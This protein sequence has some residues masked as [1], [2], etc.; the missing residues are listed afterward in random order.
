MQLRAIEPHDI[1]LLYTIEND[2]DL[3]DVSSV[4]V[5]YSRYDLEQY[6]L[7]QRHD[8]Y[9]DRQLRLV[10]TADDGKAVGLIDL[11]DFSPANSRAE[12]G[13]AIL[14]EERGKG[15]AV[16]A[17]KLLHAY[18]ASHLHI[19]QIYAIVPS[20]NVTCL[21]MLRSMGYA[22]ERVLPDWM[23]TSSGYIDC[24]ALFRVLE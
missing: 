23:Q 2:P 19:H 18:A 10:I 12:M 3:W 6:I 9:A 17:L 7:S 21:A 4:N 5:P 11:F 16:G 20:D 24:I 8:L 22:S 1:D 13:I 14:K 15:Y